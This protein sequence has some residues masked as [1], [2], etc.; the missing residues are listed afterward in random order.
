MQE[1]ATD[2]VYQISS[3]VEDDSKGMKSM[4]KYFPFMLL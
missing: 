4:Q 1:V 2:D 3:G